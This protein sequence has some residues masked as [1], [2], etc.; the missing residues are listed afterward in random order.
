M[1]LKN[2]DQAVVPSARAERPGQLILTKAFRGELIPTEADVVRH[3]A[4]KR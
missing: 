4:P 3:K 1:K 2:A